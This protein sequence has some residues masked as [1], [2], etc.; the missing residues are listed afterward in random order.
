MSQSSANKVKVTFRQALDLILPYVYQRLMEQ[1]RSVFFIILY[2]IVF[3]TA[4]LGI[5]VQDS[6]ITGTGLALVITGLT[7]FMEGLVLGLMPLGESIGI[8][9]PRKSPLPVIILFSFILG[10]GATFAEPAIGVLRAAG[11]SVLPYEAPLLYMMLNRFADLLVYSV[12]GGVGLSVVLGMLRFLYNWSL[13]PFIYI[14]VTLLAGITLFSFADPNLLLISGLAWDSGAVTT[15]PVTVPLVLALGIGI[16]RI[17]GSGD[18]GTAG[19][20]V[21]TLASLFPVASVF[22]LGIALNLSAPEPAQP[23]VF[24]SKEKYSEVLPVFASEADYQKA[25]ESA[26]KPVNTEDSDRKKESAHSFLI[27]KTADSM[28]AAARAI[29]P[30]TAFLLFFLLLILREKLPDPDVVTLGLFLSLIGMGIFNLGIELGLTNL[31]NQVGNSLPS[32]FTAVSLPDQKKIIE[33]FDKNIIKEALDENG[34]KVLFFYMKTG[35]GFEAVPFDEARLDSE[36]AVY[37][38][39]PRRGPLYGQEGE[40]SGIF[41][42]ILFAFLMG[43]GATMAEPALNALGLK[44]EEITV[45][46][47]KKNT[48]MQAVAGGVGLG[49]SLGVARIIWNVPLV[50]FLIPPYVLLLLLTWLSTEEFVNIGWD[51]AGVTTGPITVP[52]VLAMG[53][54]IGGQVSVTEGFGILAMASVSPILTVLTT[55]MLITRKRNQYLQAAAGDQSE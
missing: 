18:S 48:L 53:L 32:S 46:T 25:A 47:F 26:L 49:I 44:V 43:Y 33:E 14:L 31:G 35:S 20:G 4:V 42:V 16:S 36:H 5:P 50:W 52:L 8:R 39:I 13:K 38:H 1:V 40:L 17:S 12:A 22:I 51:S 3:Q 54:G 41:V 28:I 9:L 30:L 15:G 34:N 7:F 19:F 37:E 24:F 27:S 55:G 11:A 23:E 2:L 10:A 29:L 45:G 6:L 21:V